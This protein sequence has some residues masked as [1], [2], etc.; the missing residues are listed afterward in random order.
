[1][2]RLSFCRINFVT[3]ESQDG[4]DVLFVTLAEV[5]HSVAQLRNVRRFPRNCGRDPIGQLETFEETI[6]TS[7]RQVLD[8]MKKRK[9]V[10]G[11]FYIGSGPQG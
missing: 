10:D 6:G 9:P 7:K 1:M 11:R 4:V 8:Q 3:G 2:P 5:D